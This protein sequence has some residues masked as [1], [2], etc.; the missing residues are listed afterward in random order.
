MDH[1]ISKNAEDRRHLQLFHSINP[2]VPKPPRI[3]DKCPGQHL[4]L[5]GYQQNNQGQNSHPPQGILR[6]LLRSLRRIPQKELQIRITQ[7]GGTEQHDHQHQAAAQIGDGAAF[8]SEK[9]C[10]K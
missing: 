3:K 7:T 6:R 2:E 4:H 9:G 1:E 5:P 8:R 10:W